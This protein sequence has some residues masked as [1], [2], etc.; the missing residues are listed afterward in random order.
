MKDSDVALPDLEEKMEY[1][2]SES[3]LKEVLDGLDNIEDESGL[4]DA[5]LSHNIEYDKLA[6]I[7]LESD[8]SVSNGYE[9]LYRSVTRDDD[10][11]QQRFTSEAL[12]EK[13]HEIITYV[14]QEVAKIKEGH[15]MNKPYV[16][17]DNKIED[18]KFYYIIKEGNSFWQFLYEVSG[19]V[20]FR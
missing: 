1:E 9:R 13:E 8:N 14:Q 18:M 19:K 20:D 5:Y 16:A 2:L 7:D 11:L 17:L 12:S 4:R 15:N 3:S 6:P 10:D